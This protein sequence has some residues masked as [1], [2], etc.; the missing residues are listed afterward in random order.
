MP[1]LS[2]PVDS[3]LLNREFIF[4]VATSSYQIEGSRD[5]RLDSIWDTF[6][7]QPGRIAD[8]SN[9]DIACE[10]IDRWADD[11]ELIDYLGVDAYRLSIS[12]PRVVTS[13]GQPNPRGL[14]FYSTLIN[15]LNARDIK[16][17]VTL[18]HWDLPQYLEDR[19]GWLNRQTAYEFEKYADIVSHHLG[20]S[21]YAYAT[22]NEPFCSAYLGYELG[23]HAPGKTGRANGR[24]AAHHLLLAHGLAMPVL[25]SNAPA[26]LHGIVLNFSTSYAVSA[27]T[28][29]QQAAALADEY[30]NHWYAMPVLAGTYPSVMDQLALHER[31]HIEP[32]DM[33]LICQ[34]IDYLG[35][36][37]YNPSRYKA[38]DDQW[39]EQV[40]PNNTEVTD[41]GWEVN[42]DSFTDLLLQ[43]HQRYDLPP[44]YITE[45]GAATIDE[46]KD[47][48]VHDA[49]RI[50]YF[51]GHLNAVDTAIR[52]GVDI[53]GY[54][55]WS[56]MDN[57]EWALGYLKRFG[58]V[59]VDYKTQQ[60]TVKHSGLAYRN[61]IKTRVSVR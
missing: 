31:P 38:G 47:G 49:Q 45:N 25:R 17:F 52:Q 15:A 22:L 10:H 56:L 18:Y 53:R 20:N 1:N 23:I 60:R 40:P 12:W 37:F 55:A 21:V 34:P 8:G 58:I 41:M 2:L 24:Q 13:E 11:V 9:G 19:G 29:D 4:G 48:Q 46:L 5:D 26:S 35:V 61:L 27:S 42:P 36:N 14:A 44:V 51:Q 28:A 3:P 43:L 59:Y 50:A 16:V 33:A 39:F 57:F 54:F 7:A 6:C 32:Q 30:L